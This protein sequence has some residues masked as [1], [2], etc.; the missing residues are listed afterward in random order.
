MVLILS[1]NWEPS[2]NQVIDWLNYLNIKW[3]R[4][5]ESDRLRI[6]GIE[7]RGNEVSQL[8]LL[9]ND[10]VEVDLDKFTSYWYRRGFLNTNHYLEDLKIIDSQQVAEQIKASL[11]DDEKNIISF[12]HQYLKS[13]K[14]NINSYLTA[15]ND[16]TNYLLQASLSALEVPDTLVCDNK[17]QLTAFFNRN[18]GKIICKSINEGFTAK[19]D[20]Y[21]YFNHTNLVTRNDI[22]T[23]SS[24]FF[25]TLFQKYIEKLFELRIF[26]LLGE[27]YT[28]AIFSQQNEKTKVD[29]RNYDQVNPNRNIPYQL[30][31]EIENK[32]DLFMKRIGL[33]CG[34]I[35]MILTKDYRYV[36]LE[37]NPVGQFN[38]VSIPCNYQ[39]EKRIAEILN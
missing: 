25:P 38:M 5:N 18:E 9:L 4:I 31:K 23:C 10:T 28:M 35:D 3:L 13:H 36:F 26:Y 24:S 2:T 34:S 14:V 16:K 37:V 17:E 32:L 6:T 12:I 19:A 39:L 15:Y 1:D 21:V 11:I 20:G 29:F 30:P 8:Q 7:F 22:E 33:N 27:F